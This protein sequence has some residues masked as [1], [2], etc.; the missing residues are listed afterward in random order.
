MTFSEANDYCLNLVAEGKED[1]RVPT[2]SELEVIYRNKDL[3]QSVTGFDEFINDYYWCS[4]TG[5]RYGRIVMHLGN[6]NVGSDYDHY[7]NYI[8][9]VRSK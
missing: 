3:L 6:G 7:S 4:D 1:W 5:G 9:C 8:R 2:K